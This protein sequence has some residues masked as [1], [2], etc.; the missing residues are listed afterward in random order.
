MSKKEKLNDMAQQILSAAELLI[1]K[2]GLQ[3][4]SMR[5]LP[6]KPE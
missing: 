6:A 4:L 1:A 5:K 3:N 2:E